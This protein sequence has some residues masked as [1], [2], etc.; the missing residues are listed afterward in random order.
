MKYNLNFSQPKYSNSNQLTENFKKSYLTS[1]Q[2]ILDDDKFKEKA[3]TLPLLKSSVI[4]K[5]EKMLARK[6]FKI[7][8]QNKGKMGV[9]TNNNIQNKNVINNNEKP[10]KNNLD[11]N[12][13]KIIQTRY[14]ILDKQ[15]TEITLKSIE[16]NS[17]INNKLTDPFNSFF[18]ES[19]PKIRK[20]AL[21]QIMN[22][23][24]VGENESKE[25][26]K[27]ILPEINNYKNPNLELDLD[28]NNTNKNDDI[29]YKDLET[30]ENKFRLNTEIDQINHEK[31]GNAINDFET[32]CVNYNIVTL[33][34]KIDFFTYL[35]N[36]DLK[37]KQ[38]LLKKQT[39]KKTYRNPSKLSSNLVSP[40]KSDKKLNFIN[41]NNL[42][43]YLKKNIPILRR[44]SKL[45]MN[46]LEGR[47]IYYQELKFVFKISE[48]YIN[49]HPKLLDKFE[50]EL[51]Y[52]IKN[53]QIV[54]TKLESS[55]KLID[56]LKLYLFIYEI[57]SE[58]I[59]LR[60]CNL[61][62]D[63]FVFLLS[64][65]YF[66]FKSLKH[67]NISKN[68]LGDLGGA[69]F[70]HL[71]SEFS[72]DLEYL[73]ISYTSIGKNSCDILINSLTDD[74]L[75]IKTLNISGNNL[76]DELFSEILV[77]ISS[78]N[79]V[80]KLYISDNNLGRIG[81]NVI[82]NF[83]KYDKKIKLLDVSK[84]NF[85]DEIIAFML[86][87]LII[88]ASLDILFLNDLGLTNRSFR[89][90]DTTLS[91]NTNL[92]KLFL[93]K[94]KFN[95]KGIQKL[96]DILNSNKYLEYISL[97]GN[98]FEYEH[99]NYA[100]EQQR[101]IKLKVISKSE[102]FNQIGITENKNSIYDYLQ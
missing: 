27:D 79:H 46:L 74:H 52:K 92:K 100:D 95:Y 82:G 96:S 19:N 87:G 53:F 12:S 16:E 18:Q 30:L 33:G 80:N 13:K 43:S 17:E 9:E 10:K 99:I 51:N 1:L 69:Y 85:D 35:Y 94:N 42:P 67:V 28:N 32:K 56:K 47:L 22:N 34:Q 81:S 76:G 6:K 54:Q 20:N 15:L 48:D 36:E 50:R 102:F 89:T 62:P 66:N 98:N 88:N 44:K 60:E 90:F 86:K 37:K 77:A 40:K 75:K 8:S 64:K 49:S 97:A 26:E 65:Q 45:S 57:S 70:L 55:T 58:K 101:H 73:N 78:N 21:D 71:I 93:E 11:I 38:K 39:K 41:N 83:L 91:I 24:F 23:I 3:E 7:Q 25:N 63:S 4:N 31:Y 84:N 14:I 61:N 2:L 59:I 5:Y 68:N 72:K 29:F